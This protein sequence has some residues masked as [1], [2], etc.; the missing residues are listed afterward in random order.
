MGCNLWH[1]LL[2]LHLRLLRHPINLSI[3]VY[4]LFVDRALN[5]LCLMMQL[6]LLSVNRLLSGC[7]LLRGVLL[8]QRDKLWLLLWLLLRVTLTQVLRNSL[9]RMVAI[10]LWRWRRV[11]VPVVLLLLLLQQQLLL[12]MLTSATGIPCCTHR[13]VLQPLCLFVHR[14]VVPPEV[15]LVKVP[16]M[17]SRW[18]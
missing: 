4:L 8:G 17:A 16:S 7:Q 10:V 2:M 14:L 18:I 9:S 1:L 5:L 15:S 3:E 13:L 12:V 6:L 11:F